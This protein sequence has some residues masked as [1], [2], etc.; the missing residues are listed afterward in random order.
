MVGALSF[1]DAEWLPAA[2]AAG[3]DGEAALAYFREQ[4]LGASE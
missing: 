3:I 1:I 4:A 2:D